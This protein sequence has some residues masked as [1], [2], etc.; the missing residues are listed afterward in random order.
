[1]YFP[2]KVF[3]GVFELPLLRD[4]QKRHKKIS[5]I[6]KKE[7]TYLPH[8]SSARYTSLSILF[9]F[10][11][12]RIGYHWVLGPW[13][14]VSVSGFRRWRWCVSAGSAGL[15]MLHVRA[16]IPPPGMSPPSS[17]KSLAYWSVQKRPSAYPT[18]GTLYHVCPPPTLNHLATQRIGVLAPLQT[19]AIRGSCDAAL[20][21]LH[22]TGP[23]ATFRGQQGHS[24]RQDS[25]RGSPVAADL[26]A[27]PGEERQHPNL[28]GTPLSQMSSA[29][30]QSLGGFAISS[31]TQLPGLVTAVTT[32]FDRQKPCHSHDPK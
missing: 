9:F 11:A 18:P 23:A 29:Y 32:Y 17:P 26:L 13:V 15:A 14:W 2:Q 1:M 28:S 5:K 6:K 8:L 25:T 12:P 31:C 30:Q 7:G 27:S 3:H 22:T 4:A 20:L 24:H 21:V 19:R 10:G 16:P